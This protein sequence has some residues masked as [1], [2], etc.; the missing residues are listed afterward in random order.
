MTPRVSRT[1]IVPKYSVIRIK[2]NCFAVFGYCLG[3]F[4]LI[5]V[6]LSASEISTPRIAVKF[7]CL[8]EVRHCVFVLFQLDVSPAAIIPRNPIIRIEF[9]R[10]GEQFRRPLLIV[11]VAEFV[12]FAQ[13][14]VRQKRIVLVD[15][16][17]NDNLFL[18]GRLGLNVFLLEP[19]NFLLPNFFLLFKLLV[20]RDDFGNFFF[21]FLQPLFEVVGVNIRLDGRPNCKAVCFGQGRRVVMDFD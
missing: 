5:E 6:N 9:N 18:F 7:D 4:F 11:F 10:L 15:D 8:V 1:A 3:V 14:Q 2:A 19:V 12:A 21:V 13:F 16:L 20:L 17:L